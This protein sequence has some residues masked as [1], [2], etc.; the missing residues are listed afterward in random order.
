MDYIPIS[1]H[2]TADV[3]F[4]PIIMATPN[5]YNTVYTTP[6]GT[7]EQMNALGQEICPIAFDMGLLTRA[8][9]IVWSRPV[10]LNGV[11]PM[12]AGM[13]FLMSVF[14]WNL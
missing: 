10:E 6:K 3:V 1:L 9:G 12:E 2:D 11:V 13:H 14:G 4:N 8:L 7:K 5:D